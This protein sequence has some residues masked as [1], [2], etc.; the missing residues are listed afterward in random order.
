MFYMLTGGRVLKHSVRLAIE[1]DCEELILYQNLLYNQKLLHT[2]THLLQENLCGQYVPKR[3]G[4]TLLPV[5]RE[6]FSSTSLRFW[7]NNLSKHRSG[8]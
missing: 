7:Q 8:Q 1:K 6:Y 4:L 5:T 3:A 2:S